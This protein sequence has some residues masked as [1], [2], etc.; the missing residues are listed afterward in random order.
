V[1]HDEDCGCGIG[2][3]SG[4]GTGEAEFD[5]DCGYGD[6][7]TQFVLNRPFEE[8]REQEIWACYHGEDFWIETDGVDYSRKENI[9]DGQES[10]T[11]RPTNRFSP[12]R[13]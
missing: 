10:M 9:A 6:L 13:E 5:C 7:Q 11:N 1:H 8:R 12:A 3:D 2:C 4:C